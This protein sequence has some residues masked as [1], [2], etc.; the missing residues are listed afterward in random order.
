MMSA[1]AKPA[2][3]SPSANSTRLDTFEGLVGAGSTP[4]VNM[5][6][7]SNG[8]SSAIAST[9]SITCGSGSYSTSISLSA[10]LAIFALVAATAAT[11][12][13]SYSTFS[14]AM[15]LRTMSR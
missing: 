8:A 11:A 5:S 7:C 9:T 2:A 12:W 10:S 3:V 6:S 13:P 1:C 15:T 4:A 14:R